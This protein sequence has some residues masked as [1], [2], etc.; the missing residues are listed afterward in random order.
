[1]VVSR[2]ILEYHSEAIESGTVERSNAKSDAT[3]R[4]GAIF[5]DQLMSQLAT[6]T[7]KHSIE[8]LT[9]TVATV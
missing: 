5:Y 1:M 6:R 2:E 8:V 4:R 3:W 9:I 7:A